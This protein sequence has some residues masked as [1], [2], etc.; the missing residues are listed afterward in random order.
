MFLKNKNA[1]TLVEMLVVVLI[2]GIL[3]AI[4]LP[5]Y[6]KAVDRSRMAGELP[7]LRA[8]AQ[9]VQACLTEQEND[10][11]N[12][13]KN[14]ANLGISVEE[15]KKPIAPATRCSFTVISSGDNLKVKLSYM[16]HKKADGAIS[17][18][19]EA[20]DVNGLSAL[21]CSSSGIFPNF[22]PKLGFKLNADGVYEL[23]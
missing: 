8:V 18:F 1:F 9:A 2:I 4:A 10:E 5:Q 6:Q 21:Q 17:I 16:T 14:I 13:C 23:N 7:K 3:S 11:T 19:Y 12:A 15:C 20:S 22:C